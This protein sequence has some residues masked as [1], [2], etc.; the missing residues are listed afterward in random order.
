MHAT[1]PPLRGQHYQIPRPLLSFRFLVFTSGGGRGALLQ[2][3]TAILSRKKKEVGVCQRL[4]CQKREFA[5][6]SS[7][8]EF[9]RCEVYSSEVVQA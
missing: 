3:P 5:A 2:E 8:C 9:S 1:N 6:R 7:S 4:V